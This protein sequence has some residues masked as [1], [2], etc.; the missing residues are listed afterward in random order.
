MRQTGSLQKRLLV[1]MIL[2]ALIPALCLL[3]WYFHY[4]RQQTVDQLKH[5]S[6]QQL[7]AV[8]EKLDLV[9]EQV[10]DF[11]MW[12][13]RSE[14]LR[15]LLQRTGQVSVYDET[16]HQA[17][18]Q[19]R[20]QFYYRPIAQQ[21]A[22]LYILGDNGLE[23]RY[24]PDSS[25]IG[26][27]QLL[28]YVQSLPEGQHWGPQI[29]APSALAAEQAGIVYAHAIPG[30]DGQPDCGTMVLL[31]S[32][33]V[34]TD[35]LEALRTDQTVLLTL[36]SRDGAELASIQGGA[37]DGQPVELRQRSQHTQWELCWELTAAG[38]PAQLRVAVLSTGAF[39]L[40]ALLL[41]VLL[42]VFLSHN[43]AAPVE[44]II[45][46]VSSIAKG[47]FS[48]SVAAG[49]GTEIGQLADSVNRMSADLQQL[50]REKEEKQQLEMRL[51]QEQINP[52]FLYNTLSSIKLMAGMQGKNSIA[53]IIEALG[54]LLRANLSGS[55]DQITLE[56]EFALLDGY[57][58][59]QNIR[60]KGNVD[61]TAQIEEGLEGLP[62][63]KFVLQP[64]VENAIV[65]G[66]GGRPEGGTIMVRAVREGDGVS[67]TVCDDGKGIPEQMRSELQRSLDKADSLQALDREHGIGLHNTACRL[68]LQCGTG[69]RVRLTPRQPCGLCVTLWLPFDGGNR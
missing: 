5:D 6:E 57:M 11:V 4:V 37:A 27:D 15:A 28:P 58:Y 1:Y 51:L 50:L 7:S 12:T 18:A 26:P 24:G 21:I 16:A 19:L 41:I 30:G 39:I 42:A 60:L 54:R 20:E 38:L 68:R 62:V 3:C 69:C 25:L 48:Q 23:L 43:L 46:Q 45:R 56:E 47:D 64:L 33:D 2:I 52:H 65:H 63:P 22:A 53:E 35:E 55:R 49:G 9:A 59:I 31:F 66:I 8:L 36:Y 29:A 61:Y 67:I 13:S 32:P 44:R 17:L 34:V 40:I 14:P 10:N